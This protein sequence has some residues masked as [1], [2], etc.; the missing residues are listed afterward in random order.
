MSRVVPA[1]AFLLLALM[2]ALPAQ[3]L[4]IEDDMSGDW[5]T[6]AGVNVIPPWTRV[7]FSGTAMEANDGVLELATVGGQGVWFGNGIYIGSDPGWSFGTRDA[8]I[9]VSLDAKFSAD[10]AGWSLYFYDA[11]GDFA[12]MNFNEH[13]S[14]GQPVSQGVTYYSGGENNAGASGFV[15]MDLDD[16][17]HRFEILLKGGQVSYAIDG[18][19]AFSGAALRTNVANLLV[20]GDGSGSTPTGVGSMFIEHVRVDTAPT[21]DS[22][23]AVPVPAALP[24]FGSALLCGAL[25][26]RRAASRMPG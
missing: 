23:A 26:R 22:L 21:I 11:S 24:L 20:I 2:G 5:T 12:L 15:S 3:A 18:V 25:A 6:P 7:R 1:V 8:G 10:A 13:A 14:Y 4:I 9:H 16:D 19:L 17:F